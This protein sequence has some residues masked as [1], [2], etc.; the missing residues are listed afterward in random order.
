MNRLQAVAGQARHLRGWIP[1]L[2]DRRDKVLASTEEYHLPVAAQLPHEVPVLDQGAVGSCTANMG[3]M[4]M[5]WLAHLAGKPDLEFSRLFLYAVTRTVEGTPLVEDSG[6]Q[7]R[8]VMKALSRFGACDEK[9]WPYQ[10]PETSFSVKPS[11][12]AFADALNHQA[13]FYYRCTSLRS[14]KAS[15]AQGFPV[16]FGFTVYAAM[17]SDFVAQTGVLTYPKD[18]EEVHGGHAVVAVGFD[19]TKRVDGIPGAVLCQNS[20]G[21][22]WGQRGFFWMPYRYFT[23]GLADDMWTLRRIEL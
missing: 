16:G 8:S 18:D 6:A 21:V 11:A 20:W 14:L 9:L 23:D 4:Q 3:A 5:A 1:D 10:S 15:I 13:L 7:I 17:M 2:P 12:E 19:D 22:S